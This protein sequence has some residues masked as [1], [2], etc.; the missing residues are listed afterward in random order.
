MSIENQIQEILNVF[1]EKIRTVE[2]ASI[3]K[4]I[5]AFA[6]EYG[7]EVTKDGATREVVIVE[8]LVDFLGQPTYPQ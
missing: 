6:G 1:V 4:E 5:Q 8:Q 3:V 2:R 7:H